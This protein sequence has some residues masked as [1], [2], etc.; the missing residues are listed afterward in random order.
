MDA[1]QRSSVAHNAVD[2]GLTVMASAQ[3]IW[4]AANVRP[5]S[6]TKHYKEPYSMQFLTKIITTSEIM[7]AL[8]ELGHQQ[9]Y[10]KVFAAKRRVLIDGL[11]KR[12]RSAVKTA[13]WLPLE[14][15]LKN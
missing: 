12:S 14:A 8:L 9:T 1:L 4:A 3:T 6:V 10:S 2:T 5:V 7:G 11:T 15:A 13:T